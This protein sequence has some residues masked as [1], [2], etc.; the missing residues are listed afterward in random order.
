MTAI[1]QRAISM[2]ENLPEEKILLLLSFLNNLNE[3]RQLTPKEIAFE[4][5]E[6]LCE[7]IPQLDYKKEFAEYREER[8]GDAN[9]SAD[10]FT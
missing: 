4:K 1:R 8:F 2:V 5:L 6:K 3:N 7:K 9:F 10:Y